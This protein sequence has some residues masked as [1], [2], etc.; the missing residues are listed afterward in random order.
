MLIKKERAEREEMEEEEHEDMAYELEHK[1]QFWFRE[2]QNPNADY[3]AVKD[4][5]D[6]YF[7]NHKWE[8]SRPREYGVSWIKSQIFYL[9]ENGRVQSPPPFDQDHYP[10]LPPLNPPGTTTRTVGTWHMLGPVNST[11]YSN[12]GH[13]NRGGY[14]FL[15]RIDPTNSQKMFVSFVTGGLWMT[16]DGGVSWTLLMPTGRMKITSILMWRSATL[17]SFMPSVV[18]V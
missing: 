7:A 5:F 17:P 16:S 12:S 13:G 18:P 11:D 3:F 4:S 15:N 2:M 10:T 8:E 14:V 1:K 6:L 9:D